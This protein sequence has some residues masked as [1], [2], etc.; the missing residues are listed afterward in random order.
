MV[1]QPTISIFHLNDGNRLAALLSDPNKL[2][3]RVYVSHHS[4]ERMLS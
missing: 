4:F 3:D 1:K 2:F